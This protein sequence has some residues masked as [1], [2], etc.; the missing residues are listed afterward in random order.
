[1]SGSTRDMLPDLLQALEHSVELSSRLMR[2]LQWFIDAS[3][4]AEPLDAA[5]V[6]QCEE[7]LEAMAQ[8]NDRLTKGITLWWTLVG[9]DR[10][11]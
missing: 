11:Q 6:Q 10:P 1:M 8:Q 5:L 4:S 9:R 2:V 3:R 7:Q